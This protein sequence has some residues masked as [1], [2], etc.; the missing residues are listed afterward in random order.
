MPWCKIVQWPHANQR[1]GNTHKMKTQHCGLFK[2]CVPLCAFVSEMCAVG[3]NLSALS[4]IMMPVNY[5]KTIF[6]CSFLP[7]TM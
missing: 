6:I 3:L 5:H 1:A 4:F 2:Y 7:L